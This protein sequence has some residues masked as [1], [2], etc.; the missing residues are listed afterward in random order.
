[1]REIDQM[2]WNHR[3]FITHTEYGDWLDIRETY[4]NEEGN[5][6]GWTMDA[7]APGGETIEELRNELQRMLACLDKP[8]LEDKDSE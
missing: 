5:V 8:V 7:I 4:Y 6:E 2:T 1:M 3:V